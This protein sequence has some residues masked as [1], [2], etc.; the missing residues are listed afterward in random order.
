MTD[1]TKI[2]VTVITGFLGAGKTTLIRHLM[3]N[4]QGKRLAILVNEFGTVGVDGDILKSCADANCPVENIVELANG[5]IC[6]TV[7]DDFIPTIEALMAMPERPDHILIETSGLALPKPLLKAFDWPAIRSRITVDGVVALADAE[8]VAA[9]RFAP[10]VAA[11]DAQRAA[12]DSLD[13]ETPLSEVFEDQIACADIILLTKADLAGDAGLA[14]ARSVIEAELPRKLPIL[15]VTDGT[16]DPRVILGL[17]AA[18]EDDLA[19]RPSHHDGHD[20]HEHDDFES[21]V[22]DLPEVGDVED[23]VARIQRLAHE[24]HILR[25]KGYIAVQGKPMRLLVQ[26]VGERVRHQFDRPWGASPRQSR[27]VVIAEH[28]DID[29]PAI[30]AV[31]GA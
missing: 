22:I 26:A 2:P 15:P 20:D 29:E 19:A 28:H 6:C 23:L 11:V 9:G 12:D 24:Q 14:A 4:P 27:L 25:V 7:A 21:V 10:D 17:N 31:L 18:A 5:C 3:Q 13:H 8:A 16:I 1:L 30:R